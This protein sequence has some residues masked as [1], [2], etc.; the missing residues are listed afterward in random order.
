M[1]YSIDKQLILEDSAEMKKIRK[2]TSLEKDD[3]NYKYRSATADLIKRNKNVVR[4]TSDE[5]KDY[6]EYHKKQ[7]DKLVK[8]DSVDL[9]VKDNV[10]R[11]FNKD[12]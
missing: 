8:G 3:K 12:K 6:K 1:I 4:N 2:G 10:K 7:I 11:L 9:Q 5:N